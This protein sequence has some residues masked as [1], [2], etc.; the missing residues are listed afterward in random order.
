MVESTTAA[1]A[2][3][4]LRIRARHRWCVTGTPVGARGVDDLHGLLLFLRHVSRTIIAGI[5]VAFFQRVP[6][7]IARLLLASELHSS[8]ECQ[9]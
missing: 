5:W 4:A 3:M 7:I 2:Q 9:R 1:T 8:K 6:A